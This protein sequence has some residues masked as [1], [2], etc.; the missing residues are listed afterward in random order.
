LQTFTE[1]CKMW[2][3]FICTHF[4]CSQLNFSRFYLKNTK[5][6]NV[7]WCEGL[8]FLNLN[9]LKLIDLPHRYN[10]TAR[11]NLKIDIFQVNNEYTLSSSLEYS[12]FTWNLSIFRPYLA[13]FSH[14]IYTTP[15][16]QNLLTFRSKIIFF[17]PPLHGGTFVYGH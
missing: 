13:V 8:Q 12:F 6:F 10:N 1:E 5:L 7:V 16:W 2:P 14:W 3:K 17:L 11:L 9:R 15:L 4:F